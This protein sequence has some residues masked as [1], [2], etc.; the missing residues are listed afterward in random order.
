MGRQIEEMGFYVAHIGINCMDEKS[1][2][3]AANTFSGIFGFPVKDGKSSLFAGK[4]IELL[5]SPGY[6]SKGHIAVMSNDIDESIRLLYDNGV[7]F[8]W[9]S[10]SKNEKGETVRIFLKNEIE[11]F[12]I[13]LLRT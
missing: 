4:Q 1:A 10:I 5:K 6:G 12:A 8:I 2:S 13:H 9:D 11:G 7:D 3:Q